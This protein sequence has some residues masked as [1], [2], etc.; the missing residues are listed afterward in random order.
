MKT[1]FVF[2]F[3]SIKFSLFWCVPHLGSW[4]HSLE[5]LVDSN[6]DLTSRSL[7]SLALCAAHRVEVPIRSNQ[8]FSRYSPPMGTITCSTPLQTITFGYYYPPICKALLSPLKSITS[9]HPILAKLSS[10]H[11]LHSKTPYN[12]WLKSILILFFSKS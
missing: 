9:L 11:S 4:L 7:A 12:P 3:C 6:S 5:V 1:K 10:V 2:P 8:D